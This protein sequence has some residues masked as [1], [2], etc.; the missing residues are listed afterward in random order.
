VALQ[1]SSAKN[2]K[3]CQTEPENDSESTTISPA[4]QECPAAQI[5]DATGSSKCPDTPQPTIAELEENF[6]RIIA[7]IESAPE[8]SDEDPIL[9]FLLQR[10]EEIARDVQLIDQA[11]TAVA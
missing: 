11:L 1:F 2:H 10:R 7:E 9:E 8:M 3:E 5:D 4:T 6:S